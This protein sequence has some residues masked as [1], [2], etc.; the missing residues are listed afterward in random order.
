MNIGILGSSYIAEC[1]INDSKNIDGVNII[2]SYSRSL[3]KAKEFGKKMNISKSFDNMDMFLNDL[4]IDTIYISSP[5]FLH[6]EH[7]IKAL[8]AGKHVLI[9]KP[10]VT[11]L[12]ELEELKRVADKN[13][14]FFME[15]IIPIHTPQFNLLRETINSLGDI[16]VASFFQLQ[17]S[18][19]YDNY[20]NK[21]VE[22]VF[23]VEAQG[24]SLNDI[25]IYPLYYPVTL[26]GIPNKVTATSTIGF[27]GIDLDGD[28]TLSYNGFDVH[29]IHSKISSDNKDSYI[30]AGC[31]TITMKG[32]TRLTDIVLNN[33]HIFKS[34]TEA[35]MQYE[36]LDF[37]DMIVNNDYK[38]FEYYYQLS[39]D[40]ITV[41]DMIRKG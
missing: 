41:M 1:F 20:L 29:V 11:T 19:R 10:I 13:N 16:T 25:G 7:S 21:V 12:K 39:H 27:N 4:D 37:K 14:K 8:N 15:A 31:D 23:S 22:N 30:F 34:E 17:R 24:G 33:D 5:N 38:S 9:E 18:S 40:M 2:S 3:D 36:L 26:F 6:F 32:V 28:V 35:Y